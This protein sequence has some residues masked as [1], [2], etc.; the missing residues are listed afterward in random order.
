MLQILCLQLDRVAPAR[1]GHDSGGV[2]APNHISGNICRSLGVGGAMTI[3]SFGDGGFDPGA[4]AAMSEALEAAV[5]ELEGTG[6]PEVVRE[7]IATRII[8]AAKLGERNP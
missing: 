7:R 1:L 3:R 2:V 6:E 4:I 8:A 5:K